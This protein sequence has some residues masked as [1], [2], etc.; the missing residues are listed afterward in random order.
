MHRRGC[1]S[2][3]WRA[4]VGLILTAAVLISASFVT[5]ETRGRTRR[6]R[7]TGFVCVTWI[8]IARGHG[9]KAA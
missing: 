5:N 7:R 4:F 2:L 9:P 8:M 6:M 1:N 3:G